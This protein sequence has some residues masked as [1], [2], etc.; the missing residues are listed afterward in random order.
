VC[1]PVFIVGTGRCGSTMLS[2]IVRQHPD[3]LSVSEFFTSLASQAFLG[4]R[5]TGKAVIRR[6]DT[7]TPEGRT[8]L[9]NGL[10][11]DEFLYEFTDRSRY[12]P[13]NIPP[14]MGTTMPHITDDAERTW[15]EL[16]AALRARGANT[17]ADQ[18]RF[19]FDWL[20]HR[21]GK[22]VWIER[23]GASL[24]FVQT[25]AQLFPDA[26][27][28][29]IYRDGRDTALSMQRHHFFRWRVLAAGR[30]RRLGIDPFHPFNLPGTSPWV[31]WLS[32]VW[33]KFIFPADRYQREVIELPS[34]GRFW[35]DMIE[36]GT[37]YLN[38]LPQDRVLAMSYETVLAHPQ[39]ELGRFIRFVGSRF[40]DSTWIETVAALARP[41]EPRWPRLDPDERRALADAC[42]PGQSILGYSNRTST[43]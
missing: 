1:A 29:H 25:L 6:L 7:L 19:V 16:A 22:S 15:D 43:G 17:L 32:W 28:V 24:P 37:G 5:L 20:A 38:A 26:R 33:F 12:Q 14:V 13:H 34:F 27:F 8:L 4:R 41:Q 3:I 11:V 36:R 18:Y 42:E 10:Q 30:M 39:E 40:E 35:S 23:S 9:E 2:N 31:P 21:F